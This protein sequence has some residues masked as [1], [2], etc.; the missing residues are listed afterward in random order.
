[1][2]DE[3][4]PALV[5]KQIEHD[6]PGWALGGERPHA[7][8][9]RV[10]ALQEMVERQ[11]AIDRHDNLSVQHEPAGGDGSEPFHH[12]R[13]IADER[14][15]ALR[16]ELDAVAVSKAEA[17]EAVPLRLVLPMFAGGYLLN[18]EGLHGR[19]CTGPR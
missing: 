6:E 2:L 10:H 7:P 8:F 13:E 4:S 19:E 1:M 14:L 9:G 3:R 18:E 15:T 16:L 11:L 5:H 12:V 17:P